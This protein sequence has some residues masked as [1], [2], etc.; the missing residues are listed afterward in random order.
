MPPRKAM[1]ESDGSSVE[2]QE[3]IFSTPSSRETFKT[4]ALS[5]KGRSRVKQAD[6]NGGER[7]LITNAADAINFCHCIP[8]RT[9]RK[10]STVC[11]YKIHHYLF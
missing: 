8:R 2:L 3:N 1:E 4:Q 6:P 10:K 11:V 7:C 9:K 5:S